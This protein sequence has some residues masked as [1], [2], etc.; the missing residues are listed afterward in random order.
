MQKLKDK[1]T[2]K[3]IR[4][5]RAGGSLGLT[6]PKEITTELGWRE[7]QRVSIKR[8]KGGFVVRDYKNK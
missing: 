4:M 3:L 5:G 7:K 2:R 1:N 6:I 8:T